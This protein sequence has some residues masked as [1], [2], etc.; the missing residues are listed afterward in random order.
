[1]FDGRRRKNGGQMYS[2]EKKRLKS[3][4][5]SGLEKEEGRGVKYGRM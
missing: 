3:K 2:L 4:E 5:G 1:M